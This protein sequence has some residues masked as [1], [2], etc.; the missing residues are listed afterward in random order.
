MEPLLPP[1]QARIIRPFAFCF[2][3]LYSIQHT[4]PYGAG[5]STGLSFLPRKS[6]IAGENVECRE[7][8]CCLRAFLTHCIAT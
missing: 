8:S 6:G 7:M 4:L 1:T 3:H 2:Q 5:K